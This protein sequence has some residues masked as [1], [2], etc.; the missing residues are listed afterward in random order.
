MYYLGRSFMMPS[1]FRYVSYKVHCSPPLNTL[2]IVFYLFYKDFIVSPLMRNLVRECT[3]LGSD[4]EN[5]LTHCKF[6]TEL[7]YFDVN[8]SINLCCR[9]HHGGKYNIIFQ[10]LR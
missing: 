4:K 9:Y 7:V 8:W 2:R 3:S 1:G 6:F 10:T 5:L